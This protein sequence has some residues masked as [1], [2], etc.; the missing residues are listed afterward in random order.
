[1]N[2][3]TFHQFRTDQQ[4]RDKFAEVSLKTGD[5]I[6]PYFVVEG[7]GI[8]HEIEN[9]W[10]VYHLSIDVLLED[11]RVISSLGIN[12]IILFGSIDSKLK[13]EYG[14]EAYKPDNL[15]SRAV[16]KI[17]SQFPEIT[18]FTDVCLC[19]YTSHGHCGIIDKQQINNDSTLPL[20]AEMARQHALGGADFVAPSAMMDGQVAAIRLALSSISG[21]KTKILAYSAKFASGMYGPFRNAAGSAPA[22]GD[23]KS[24]QMDYR[25]ST[26]AIDEIQADIEEGAE[27]VMVKPAHTYLDI[28]ARGKSKFP[29]TP[30]A[31]YHVSGEYMLIKSA[32]KQGIVDEKTAM[33][34]CTYA[35]KRSGA[36]YI[37]TYFAKVLAEILRDIK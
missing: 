17:K 3:K 11:L 12:K 16:K 15:I 7:S 30:M 2:F 31:A 24:Y 1:M 22:F 37:I 32:A 13:N 10:D 35:I 28:I 33:L 5:F 14:T 34:E 25:N 18:V 23:R 6:Y 9:L 29:S 26:L 27:W 8:K 21:N 4:T 19:G 20:L 36:D